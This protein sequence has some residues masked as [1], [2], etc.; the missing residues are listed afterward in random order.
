MYGVTQ[1][2][3]VWMHDAEVLANEIMRPTYT[4][5]R[6]YPY[7]ILQNES[8]QRNRPDCGRACV[9]KKKGDRPWRSCKMRDVTGNSRALVCFLTHMCFLFSGPVSLRVAF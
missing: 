3:R 1:A 8:G 6:W 4:G 7:L 2:A 5:V 9:E